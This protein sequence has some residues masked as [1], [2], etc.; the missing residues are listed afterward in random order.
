LD[1]YLHFCRNVSFVKTTE[2]LT[3]DNAAV[4]CMSPV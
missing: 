3:S 4:C 2:K 1:S